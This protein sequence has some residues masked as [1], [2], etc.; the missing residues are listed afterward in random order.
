MKIKIIGANPN[1]RKSISKQR[2]RW[3]VSLKGHKTNF[4]GLLGSIE[5]QHV[6]PRRRDQEQLKH[7]PRGKTVPGSLVSLC[8]ASDEGKKR[9][10]KKN[11]NS[12]MPQHLFLKSLAFPTKCFFFT[13]KERKKSFW[14]L[15]YFFPP[16]T[17]V[18]MPW[19]CFFSP[20]YYFCEDMSE[21]EIHY[22]LWSWGEGSRRSPLM[23]PFLGSDV[24]LGTET[25]ERTSPK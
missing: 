11:K 19:T 2:L 3:Q 24:S 25:G 5:C 20:S 8:C 15:D 18:K 17:K 9:E 14:L 16:P 4:L 6:S 12:H 10:W 21:T 1:V 13:K 7:V 22:E 23:P